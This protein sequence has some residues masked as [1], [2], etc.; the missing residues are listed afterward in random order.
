MQI[1]DSIHTNGGT[2]LVHDLAS[3]QVTKEA[4]HP[5]SSH[6]IPLVLGVEAGPGSCHSLCDMSPAL[7]S[8]SYW[9]VNVWPLSGAL[10]S[11]AS[12]LTTKTWDGSG[13]P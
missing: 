9:R 12:G 5:Q 3:C 4:S 6:I 7:S 10:A 11:L 8:S 1:E 2:A 13:R